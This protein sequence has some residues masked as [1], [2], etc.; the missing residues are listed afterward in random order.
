MKNLK[1]CVVGAGNLATQLSEAL[2][3]TGYKIVQVYSRT[4]ES[5]KQLADRLQTNF[6]TSTESITT[7]ADI[8]FVALKDSAV[9]QVLSKVEFGDKLLVHCSGS[10]PMNILSSYSDN[11]GVFYPLQT[12][13]KNRKVDFKKIPI[14]LEAS[15]E[16]NL[17]ILEEIAHE[18]SESVTRLNSEK[19]KSLHIAAVFAC[20]FANH[21][22]AMAAKY[23]ESKDLSFE[24]L[25]PLIMETAQK[26]QEL[27]PKDAQTGP[28]IRF[29]E[30]I[31]NA[32]L[33]ELNEMPDL[34]ELYNSISKSIFEHH[35]EK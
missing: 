4:E 21:C 35:Q 2:A 25:R 18:V 24:I 1:M 15:S 19:R 8:Y 14:F 17:N 10:L 7:E 9:D 3:Q 12:F 34:Q 26:V 31:I 27:H 28:A 20:N 13:S 23:L 33:N 29:D 5:A 16:E 11:Y 30:N 32:H 22:Y 6:T